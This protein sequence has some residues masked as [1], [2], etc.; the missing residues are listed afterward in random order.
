M[1]MHVVIAT[2]GRPDVLVRLLDALGEQ[3]RPAAS[4]FVVGSEDRDVAAAHTHPF[5]QAGFTRLA[6]SERPGLCAQR[7]VGRDLV[8]TQHRALNRPFAVVFFD[9]DFRPASGWLRA[10]REAFLSAP[11]VVGVTGR[12]LADGV[13]GPSISE[14]AAR[15]YIEGRRPADKHFASGAHAR[16]VNCAYGCNMAFRDTVITAC[17]FDENLPLYG[18]QEDQDYSTQAIQLGRV[19]YRP[20]CL[21][22]H[23]GVKAGRVSGLRFGYSQIANPWYLARKGTMPVQKGLRF[24]SRHLV[25]NTLRSLTGHP[26]VDYR[27]RLSGNMLALADLARGRAHPLRV[28]ELHG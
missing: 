3:S 1:D 9:D 4:V 10:C 12:V 16:D 24:V 26:E 19:I 14:S 25:A 11:D 6:L 15:A 13:R 20:D 21:G 17:R 22:V 18:W 5:V 7:N 2:K 23:L 27:G 28:L 8:L